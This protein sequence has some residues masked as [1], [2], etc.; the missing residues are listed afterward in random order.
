MTAPT[1]PDYTAEL[2]AARGRL[3]R[4]LR[5]VGKALTVDG[6]SDLQAVY[7]MDGVGAFLD[8]IAEELLHDCP[9]LSRADERLGV[10]GG[11]L[12]KFAV[13]ATAKPKGGAR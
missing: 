5:R 10:I 2:L 7:L 12:R 4:L 6:L 3:G 1:M 9:W 11:T 13:K 8:T